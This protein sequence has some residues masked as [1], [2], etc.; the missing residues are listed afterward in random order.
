MIYHEGELIDGCPKD[1][2][3]N[4]PPPKP[5]PVS[6]SLLSSPPTSSPIG[7]ANPLKVGHS[8]TYYA[9]SMIDCATS[10]GQF[11]VHICGMIPQMWI[12]KMKQ[13][14][15]PYNSSWMCI[16]NLDEHPFF[17]LTAMITG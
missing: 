12:S 16:P 11:S 10:L 8:N 6:I 9:F 13:T 1:I 17:H 5:Q 7:F 15:I 14:Q 2:N 4:G 3:V